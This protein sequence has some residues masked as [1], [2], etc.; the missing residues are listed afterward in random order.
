MASLLSHASVSKPVSFSPVTCRPQRLRVGINTS[1]SGRVCLDTTAYRTVS[2]AEAERASETDSGIQV[3]W[4]Q[5]YVGSDAVRDE[6]PAPEF[7]LRFLWLQK[8]IAV[9]V[10]QVF[11]GEHKSPLTEFFF[12]PRKDAWEE[13]KAALE[14]KT[15]ISQ[16]DTILLL[17]RTTEV[18]NY[19]QEE[20][21]KHTLDEAR[22]AF[23][24]CDFFGA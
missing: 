18:I 3:D 7:R 10:D 15:W 9:A 2:R 11:A 4:T 8:N 12:W 1:F 22:E 17:N 13:L 19:W 20:G 6:V 14:A 16:R 24:D 5:K 23:P 21:E